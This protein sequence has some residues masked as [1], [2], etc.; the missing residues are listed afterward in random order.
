MDALVDQKG[1][2]NVLK[3]L[4]HLGPR[5]ALEGLVGRLSQLLGELVALGGLGEA[6]AVQKLQQR[7][8]AQA[9]QGLPLSWWK[10]WSR[11]SSLPFS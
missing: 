6:G 3:G 1:G 4:L 2:D 5:P 9:A 7:V 10:A 11:L 8:V